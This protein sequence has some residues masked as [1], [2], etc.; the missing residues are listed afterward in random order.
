MMKRFFGRLIAVLALLH[1]PAFAQEQQTADSLPWKRGPSTHAIDTYANITVP[2]GSMFLDTAST[3]ELLKITE[4]SPDPGAVTL[5][6][7]DLSWFAILKYEDTGHIA[8]DEKIDGAALLK[9]LKENE[10]AANEQKESL[11]FTKLFLDGWA[12]APHYDSLTRNLE[13][14]LKLHDEQNNTTINYTTRT[15]GRE[16]LIAATLVTSPGAFEGDL[17]KFRDVMKGL[18]FNKGETYAEFREA[19]RT[20]EYGLAALVAGGA[21]AAAVK[22]GFG[23]GFVIMIFAGIAAAFAAVVGFFKKMFGSSE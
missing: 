7:N 16:G 21:A 2:A 15:L 20:A 19:D 1:V 3:Q 9:S 18:A 10:I 5:A 12:V 22:S 14:G 11:G 13:W 6:A 17:V 8:D 23:K 4:N